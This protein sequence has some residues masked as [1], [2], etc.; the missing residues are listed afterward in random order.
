MY[1]SMKKIKTYNIVD[2][3]DKNKYINSFIKF[4]VVGVVST[5][6]NYAT[7][8]CVFRGLNSPYILA[9]IIGYI[10]GLALGYGLNKWWTFQVKQKSFAMVIKYIT[11]YMG[12]LCI[13]LIALYAL[14]EWC[15][16]NPLL[17][18]I[19]VIMI[20]TFT[21]YIGVKFFAFKQ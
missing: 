8:F 11:V 6:L 4:C 17:A 19:F 5:L 3:I 16:I 7:F 1:I 12:S 20:T 9:S 18:N 21:N 2:K 15:K 10:A 13:S 14:V